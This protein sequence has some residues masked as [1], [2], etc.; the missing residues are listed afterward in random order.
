MWKVNIIEA[1]SR[2]AHQID[3]VKEF[4]TLEEANAFVQKFNANNNLSYVPDRNMY[5]GDPY[6]WK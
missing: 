3:E 1:E 6:K 5:A 2:W 4:D